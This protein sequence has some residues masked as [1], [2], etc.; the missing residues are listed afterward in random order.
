[1]FC[2]QYFGRHARL[3]L[4]IGNTQR[5]SFCGGERVGVGHWPH[6]LICP[7]SLSPKAKQKA[8][9]SLTSAEMVLALLSKVGSS[10]GLK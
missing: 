7:F 1:M 2:H 10:G 9:N 4:F 6:R 5:E 8:A 3:L